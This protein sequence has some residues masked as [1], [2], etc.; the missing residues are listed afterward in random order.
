[1]AEPSEESQPKPN[2]ASMFTNWTGYDGPFAEKLRLAVSNTLIKVR[3]RQGC[4][5][6]NGQPGC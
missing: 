1:M 2:P 4:C 3:G 6:N 5:G